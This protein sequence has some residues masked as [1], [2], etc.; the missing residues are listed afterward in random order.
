MYDSEDIT[1]ITEFVAQDIYIEGKASDFEMI[2]GDAGYHEDTLIR[3]ILN[4]K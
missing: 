1:D 3:G 2:D 4:S